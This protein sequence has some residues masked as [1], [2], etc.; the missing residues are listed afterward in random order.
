MNVTISGFYDEISGSLTRQI[1][2]IKKL[3]ESY[4]CPRNIN[5]KNIAEYRADE[6]IRDI[7]P[8]LDKNGIK[9]SSIGSPIGKINVD[10]EEGFI[11]QKNQLKELV[12]IAQAMKCKYI[13]VFSFY[14]GDKM[15]EEC[16]EKVIARLKEFIA[17]ARGSGVTLMHENEKKVY[18]DVP[19]RVL[20]VA[21]A[22]KDEGLAFCF[23]AS[24]FVQC[25]VNPK[26]AFD[27]L[28]DIVE[29]YHI[30]DCSQY[31]VEVPLGVGMGCYDYIFA[32]LKK[33][34][35]N[36]F[37]TLEP[38]TFKYAIFKPIVYYVPFVALF[39]KN[40][41]KAF[42]LVDKKM[43]KGYFQCVSREEVFEWQYKN[44]KNMLGE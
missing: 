23:D 4:M 25:D 2:V 12:K 30:K 44:L 20:E 26:E 15:P 33:R 3:G 43:D 6:F 22:L 34:K 42:R 18:G 11:K 13:R 31:K 10:D 32:E 35:Y 1:E 24:N 14:Y 9:F 5:G 39:M 19:S 17:I 8:V 7:K 21:N 29:Y 28:K 41:Y 36:G 37:M 38:H 40:Y 27:L 16:T